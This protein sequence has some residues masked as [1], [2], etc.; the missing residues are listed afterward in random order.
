MSFK[1]PEIK[2][3]LTRATLLHFLRCSPK[4][5]QHLDNYIRHHIC[6]RRSWWDFGINLESSKEG[7]DAF[8]YDQE[9]LTWFDILGCLNPPTSQRPVQVK[10]RCRIP[11]G[12]HQHR[13]RSHLRERVTV[14]SVSGR[15]RH[16]SSDAHET[17]TVHKRL[18]KCKQNVDRRTKPFLQSLVA[19]PGLVKPVDLVLEYGLNCCG[20]VAFIELGSER[21]RDEMLSSLFFICLE[22]FFEDYIE[23]GNGC[24]R[25]G[26]LGGRAMSGSLTL[27][28]T[29]AERTVGGGSLLNNNAQTHSLSEINTR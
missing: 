27:G 17:V 15:D 8:E 11:G 20:G 28:L 25:C 2:E 24:C 13:R 19:A 18:R 9:I 16:G 21:M 29:H 10:K 23:V 22:G 1:R 4:D 26:R 7:F 6:H 12:G 3:K 5:I 14:E